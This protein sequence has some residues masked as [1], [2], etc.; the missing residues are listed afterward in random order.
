MNIWTVD[1]I[2]HATIKIL[3]IKLWE[4]ILYSQNDLL[5]NEKVLEWQN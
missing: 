2:K 3:T 4:T 5:L 1:C